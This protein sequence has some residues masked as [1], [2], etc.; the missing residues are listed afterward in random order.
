MQAADEQAPHA[1]A[2]RHGPPPV[3]N[4]AQTVSPRHTRAIADSDDISH[5]F[6]QKWAFRG[7]EWD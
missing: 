6:D 4:I 3:R 7:S 2:K 1:R 5:R